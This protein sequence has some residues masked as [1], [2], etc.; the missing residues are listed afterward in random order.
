[1]RIFFTMLI[2]TIVILFIVSGNTLA[3]S[4][5]TLNVY[6]GSGISLD[7]TIMADTT[8]NGKLAHK[9]YKLVSLDTTYVFL[10]VITITSDIEV[11]GQLGSDG[12]PP[13][14]QPGVNVDNTV[15]AQLFL[16]SGRGKS[17]TFKHLYLL[18]TSTINTTDYADAITVTEDSVR[19]VVDSVVFDV[20]WGDGVIY[21]GNW[22]KFYITNNIFRNFTSP[23][24]Y[25]GEAFRNA[26]SSGYTDTVYIRY[27]TFFC[28]YC[29]AACPVTLALV[30]YF[31]FTNNNVMW[32]FNAP[33]WIFNVTNA[34]VN[35]NI[36]YGTWA[37]GQNNTEYSGQNDEP[38]SLEVGS[39]ID[40]DTLTK[41][42]AADFGIDT[43]KT[44]WRTLAEQKRNIEV[45]NNAYFTPTE[46]TDFYNQWNDTSTSDKIRINHWMNDRTTNMFANK[47]TWA[48]LTESGN[49]NVDPG[50]GSSINSV[51]NNNVGNGI[52]LFE[53][54]TEI[55]QDNPDPGY[56]G[57]QLK[58]VG[59]DNWIPEW[60]LP[61][62]TDMKYTNASVKTGSTSG[63][64]IGDPNW[65]GKKLDAVKN[66]SAIVPAAFSLSN[67]YPNPFNPTTN[68]QFTVA[69]SENVKL[70]VFNILGQQV[71]TLVNGEM[72]AGSYTATW[73]GKDEFGTSVASGIYF[74][75]FESKSFN[76]TKKM[77][78][79]K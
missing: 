75:R 33:F 35:N 12:R 50:F 32:L 8:S 51:L 18:G 9:V 22:D 38:L 66:N 21:S 19:V 2:T 56:F 37:G 27:N 42:N 63:N 68:I 79:M 72:K 47:T 16:L 60:P 6:A 3:S 31:D 20:W 71:K 26:N 43:A 69:K 25:C 14:I 30:N 62:V 65:F 58:D 61:E 11:I 29:Y 36:F 10:D 41:R 39:I 70:V 7:E 49:I 45:K 78:L 28:G 34:K 54:F 13:C 4:N 57:Y 64:I 17:A 76:S 73:N 59:N 23:S 15:P 74:Y 48:G 44:E 53:Y 55:R 5:D 1:M 40:L 46:L 24:T 67:A 52:G 77:I